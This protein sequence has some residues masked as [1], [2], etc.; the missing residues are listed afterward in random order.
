LEAI[1]APGFSSL[2]LIDG[3]NEKEDFEALLQ[4]HFKEG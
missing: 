1:E 3:V 4:E 2:D